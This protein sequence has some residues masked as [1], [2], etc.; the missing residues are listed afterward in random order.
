MYIYRMRACVCVCAR[1]RER[2]R[3]RAH[4]FYTTYIK[5]TQRSNN[6][7][8][9]LICILL[10]DAVNSLDSVALNGGISEW[11]LNW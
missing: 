7:F 9:V 10:Q 8:T 1:E 2:E 6:Q 5:N 11:I 3:E 4:K